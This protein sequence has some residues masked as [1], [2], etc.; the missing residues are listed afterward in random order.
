MA[1]IHV[2]GYVEED[3]IPKQSQTSIAYVCFHLREYLGK[4]RWQT[5]QVWVWGS[6][7]HRMKRLGIKS[8]SLIWLTGKL[9]LVD[10]TMDH[11]KVQTKVLKVYCSDF[12]YLPQRGTIKADTKQSTGIAAADD[13]PIP[14]EIDGDRM[15]LPE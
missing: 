4:G 11:G 13:L 7:V 1:Q 6:D 3:L 14:E 2:F 8:G 12:G 9:E 10:C 5:Y 15:P